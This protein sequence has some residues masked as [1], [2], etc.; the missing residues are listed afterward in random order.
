MTLSY[1]HLEYH[2]NPGIY[3]LAKGNILQL[4]SETIIFY[5]ELRKANGK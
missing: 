5:T 2:R 4:T 1:Q 3:A